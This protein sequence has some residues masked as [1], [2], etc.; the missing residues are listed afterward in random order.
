MK[1]EKMKT[2]GIVNASPA[3]FAIHQRMGKIRHTGRGISFF[4]LPWIDRYT[5]IPSSTRTIQFKADQITAENQGVEISGFA[6]WRVADAEKAAANFDFTDPED[7][8][9]TIGGALQDVV[10]S[11]IRHQVASMTIEDTL[12]KRGS[13]IRQL[14]DEMA[15]VSGLW[16][17]GVET[18]EIKSVRILS[19]QLFENLQAPF[20]NAMRLESEQSA[21]ETERRLAEQR[22]AQ[23]EELARQKHQLE[24]RRIE[25]EGA[26][27]PHEA[28]LN[29][30][31]F[32]L[33]KA[34]AGRRLTI[35]KVDQEIE[36]AR[37][38]VSNT[39]NA[40]LAFLKSLP[41]VLK[42]L[43]IGDVHLGDPSIAALLQRI[44]SGMSYRGGPHSPQ[45]EK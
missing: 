28:E 38:A 43:R 35:S 34:E 23:Q 19:R 4:K 11:A 24:I 21:I 1:N 17:I 40:T 8:L 12:R 14:K 6:A 13:I 18:V 30:S 9:T 20:R 44:A 10:E 33:E 45:G 32:E 3:E 5:I 7:A 15:Y 29:V 27:L 16:G 2:V 36:Q 39:E 41:N 31:R 22:T 42:N 25:L 26:Q 37:I